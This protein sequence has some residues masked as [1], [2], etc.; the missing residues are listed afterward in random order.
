VLSP[1]EQVC[2]HGGVP[3]C[4]PRLGTSET[5]GLH[6][7]P[8]LIGVGGIPPG[9]GFRVQMRELL[10]LVAWIAQIRIASAALQSGLVVARSLINAATAT[11]KHGPKRHGRAPSHQ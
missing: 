1:D 11:Q 6:L 7:L 4:S 10:A 3:A 9:Q 2:D 5:T 8:H